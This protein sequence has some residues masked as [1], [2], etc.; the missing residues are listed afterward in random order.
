MCIFKELVGKGQ[1][2]AEP[3]FKA[4]YSLS[5]HP[6]FYSFYVFFESIVI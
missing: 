5:V 6:S 2:P 3:F 1:K 4:Q